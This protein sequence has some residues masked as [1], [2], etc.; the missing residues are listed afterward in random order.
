MNF[1]TQTF[2]ITWTQLF[3]KEVKQ[4]QSNPELRFTLEQE[5]EFPVLEQLIW[6]SSVMHIL[7][8]YKKLTLMLSPYYYS[9]CQ[10]LREEVHPLFN[11]G[12]VILMHIYVH[13]EYEHIFWEEKT[14]TAAAK[15][16]WH[17]R[18]LLLEL[19]CKFECSLFI[20]Y[21]VTFIILLVKTGKIVLNSIFIFI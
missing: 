18:K 4:T 9:P 13:M 10:E 20:Q 8:D 12:L 11:C 17:G 14:A 5:T 7:H 19:M 15:D 1:Y 21:S 6:V 3:I 16:N 2:L